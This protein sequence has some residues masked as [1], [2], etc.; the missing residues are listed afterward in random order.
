M[1]ELCENARYIF[2]SGVLTFHGLKIIFLNDKKEEFLVEMI[3]YF[4]YI[5]IPPML[6]S[7][8]VCQNSAFKR[9]TKYGVL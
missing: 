8:E 4:I 2:W 1:A 6:W 5:C 3:F 7:S 9:S